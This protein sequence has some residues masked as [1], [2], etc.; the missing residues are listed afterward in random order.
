MLG[1]L[2]RAAELNLC[3]KFQLGL[4]SYLS[5]YRDTYRETRW[6]AFGSHQIDMEPTLPENWVAESL[7][8]Y[9]SE[10]IM[11]TNY[12]NT[13]IWDKSVSPVSWCSRPKVNNVKGIK[14]LCNLILYRLPI[15][16][17]I[18]QLASSPISLP[19]CWS[20]SSTHLCIFFFFFAVSRRKQSW[21]NSKNQE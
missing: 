11:H 2:S 12:S 14:I 20:N 18:L 10:N 21:T 13:F 1:G 15:V 17:P 5:S 8:T 16:L 3:K 4:D 9:L 6:L 19:H 7:D